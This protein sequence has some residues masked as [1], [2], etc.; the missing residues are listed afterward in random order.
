[1]TSSWLNLTAAARRRVNRQTTHHLQSAAYWRRLAQANPDAQ[2]F[3]LYLDAARAHVN[4][5]RTVRLIAERRAADE[6]ARTAIA[7]TLDAAMTA[8]LPGEYRRAAA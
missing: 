7:A 3:G 2:G 5:A 6:A 4:E 8:P 1:M